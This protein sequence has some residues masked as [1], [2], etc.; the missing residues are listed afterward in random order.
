MKKAGL[1]LCLCIFLA[2]CEDDDDLAYSSAR[3]CLDT[4]NV[5]TTVATDRSNARSCV[6]GLAGD[7]SVRA[8]K[9]RCAAEF[10]GNGLSTANLA[11]IFSSVQ[12]GTGNEMQETLELLSFKA[13]TAPEAQDV[14]DDA[15]DYCNDSGSTGMALFGSFAY[16]A[17]LLSGLPGATWNPNSPPDLGAITGGANSSSDA[18]LGTAILNIQN[19][20]CSTGSADSD[21]C[22][23]IDDIING[24]TDP[25][26]IGDQLRNYIN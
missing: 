22:T 12:E 1:I 25:A 9:L 14:A 26:T 16:T 6:S 7:T 4:L 19:V 13:A 11:A 3:N 5:T 20:Y 8:N 2:G 18:E 23:Q 15:Y 24:S 10:L 21:I 17:T